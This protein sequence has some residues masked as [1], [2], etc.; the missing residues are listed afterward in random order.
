MESLRPYESNQNEIDCLVK[1]F[2]IGTKDIGMQFG[3]DKCG[4]LAMKRRKEVE[5]NG[6]KFKNGEKVVLIGRY[7]Y[8]GISEK[9]DI[10]QQDIYPTCT[11]KRK[12][13]N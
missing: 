4:I 12:A 10:C 11:R 2:E 9:G 1:T 8:L 13:Y 5:G 3:I 6:I 7:K